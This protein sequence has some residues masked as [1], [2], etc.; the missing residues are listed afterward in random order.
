MQFSWKKAAAAVLLGLAGFWFSRYSISFN[1]PPFTITITWSYFLPL[2]AG[3][4]YGPVYGLIAGTV[5][6]GAF[7]PFLLYPNNGWAC[8]VNSI[9]VAV[10]F[11]WY[12]YTEQHRRTRPALWNHPFF[13]YLPFAVYYVLFMRLLFPVA[14]ALNPPFWYPQAARSMPVAILDGVITKGLIVMY[15][16]VILDVSMLRV[17]AVRKIFD[18]EIKK[19]SRQNGR[20]VLVSVLGSA[21][22]WYISILFNRIFIDKTFPLGL[23]QFN[24]PH[25]TLALVVFLAAGFFMGAVTCQYVESRLKAEDES[26]KNAESYRLIFEQAAD[27][28]FLSDQNG[29]FVD[30]NESGCRLIGF[31]R[32]E[33]LRLNTRELMAY[34]SGS[35]ADSAA[36]IHAGQTHVFERR[37]R[38]QDGSPIDVE[39]SLCRLADGRLQALLHNISER[40]RSE[41]ALHESAARFQSL[42]DNS[43]I[44]HWEVDFCAVQ[45]RLDE[46]RGGG[47]TDIQAYLAKHTEVVSE[48][49]ALVKILGVNKATLD[50]FGAADK[51]EMTRNLHMLYA[52]EGLTAFRAQMVCI[53]AGGRHF[54]TETVFKA[55]D[56]RPII[57]KLNWAVIPGF[58]ADL[59][60]TI[61]SLIDITAR[62]QAEEEIKTTSEELQRLLAEADQSRKVL[63]NV[64]EDQKIAEEKL[65]LLNEELEQRVRARTLQLEAANQELEAFA[66]SVSHDLRAPL[67]GID[68]WS[69]VVL[70]DYQDRLDDYGRQSLERI[71][72]ETQRMGQMIDDILRLS[73]ITRMEMKTERVNL[74]SLAEAIAGRLQETEPQR[75][76]V[77]LIQPGLVETGDPNLLEIMLT[78]LLSN[79]WKFTGQKA[80]PVIEF[81]KTRLNDQDVYYVRDN[82]AGFDMAY[83]RNLFGAFQRMHKQSD[84]PGTGIGLATV[85]RIIHRHGGKI[86]ADAQK[87]M[88]AT[89]FFRLPEMR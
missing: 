39:I 42:L 15:L 84:F 29:Q 76:V 14:F 61:V 89:F 85:Q 78:N 11:T 83:A 32:A 3:M 16:M 30:V 55:L 17:P 48:C 22:L 63:L 58:E 27:G 56:G 20:I 75:Q 19:E 71:H 49:A 80:Q 45:Q 65:N 10:W 24:D 46:L 23:F 86:W 53:A 64:V 38:H 1:N 72:N 50:L 44:S 33:I 37:I 31:T 41:Q 67:R 8:L 68:G 87:N 81:G 79:A 57:A 59:S 7:F 35:G 5:G 43:P 13:A 51:A 4:A 28:I 62:K 18:L 70:H 6:L 52:D 25:E 2:L 77:F 54:E 60:R 9:P 12:G 34:S 74:T 21:F 82:G 69:S 26:R 36:E 40:K 47:V 66:Y 88:G 73:R